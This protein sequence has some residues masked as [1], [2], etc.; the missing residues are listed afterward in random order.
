MLGLRPVVT[1]K[2]GSTGVGWGAG[3]AS[4][5][6]V[7]NGLLSVLCWFLRWTCVYAEGQGR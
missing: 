3:R 5:K 2:G 4:C 6:Q 7:R 1:G